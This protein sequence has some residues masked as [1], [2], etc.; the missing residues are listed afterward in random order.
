MNVC[1]R[2][3]STGAAASR[4]NDARP[5]PMLPTVPVIY[6]LKL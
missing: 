4:T 3:G 5:Q 2:D 1:K 6:H